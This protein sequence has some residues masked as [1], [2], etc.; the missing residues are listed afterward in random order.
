MINYGV[1][2]N[3][4][5]TSSGFYQ[6]YNPKVS[7][8]YTIPWCLSCIPS[9][10]IYHV[11]LLCTSRTS[12]PTRVLCQLR[13][14]LAQFHVMVHVNLIYSICRFSQLVCFFPCISSVLCRRPYGLSHVNVLSLR[15]FW[16]ASA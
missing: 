5:I 14:S 4:G 12:I 9:Q 8:M 1:M 11:Y 2:I 10:G 3:Q 16:T 7:I 13:M 6:V 15:L